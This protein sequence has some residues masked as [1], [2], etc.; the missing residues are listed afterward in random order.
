[1]EDFNDYV[2]NGG[3]PIDKNLFDLVNSLASKYDG[4]NQNELLMAI[5][6]EAKRGKQAG[7]LTNADIDNFANMLSP[8]LDDKKR[9]MLNKIVGELKKI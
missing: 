2:K 3:E 8:F 5:Y 9:S 4:K 6:K 7:T 1:M